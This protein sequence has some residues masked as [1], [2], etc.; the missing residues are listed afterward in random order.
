MPGASALC[1]NVPS[2]T[3]REMAEMSMEPLNSQQGD[4]VPFKEPCQFTGLGMV[5]QERYVK[6]LYIPS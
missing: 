6:L 2:C 3:C 4:W 1:L 5:V